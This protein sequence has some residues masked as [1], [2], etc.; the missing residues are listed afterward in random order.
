[1][2][3][4]AVEPELAEELPTASSPTAKGNR[5]EASTEDRMSGKRVADIAIAP[6]NS[7]RKN[8]QDPTEITYGDD[9]GGDRRVRPRTNSSNGIDETNNTAE[10]Q[11]DGTR[12]TLADSRCGQEPGACAAGCN[13]AEELD[14][15]KDARKLAQN[16]ARARHS[17][18]STAELQELDM[19]LMQCLRNVKGMKGADKV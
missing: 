7:P 8:P 18:F 6:V 14:P 17:S 19:L 16:L 3:Y 11:K 4:F 15:I 13:R 1:M 2:C 9:F 5:R 10:S 12:A